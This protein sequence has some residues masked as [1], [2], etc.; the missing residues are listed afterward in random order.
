MSKKIKI[1]LG[2]IVFVG[3]LMIAFG[4]AVNENRQTPDVVLNFPSQSS[5]RVELARILINEGLKMIVAKRYSD[6]AEV[7]AVAKLMDSALDS[8]VFAAM[9]EEEEGR[10]LDNIK[11]GIYNAL[12]VGNTV[13]AEILQ[14]ILKSIGKK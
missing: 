9:L 14:N 5:A 1:M 3:I 13:R 12:G 11:G 7:M 2:I 10:T 6:A 8:E 4:R